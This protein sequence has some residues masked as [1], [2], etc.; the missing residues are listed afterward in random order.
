MNSISSNS[1]S[2]RDLEDVLEEEPQSKRG[3]QG[4]AAHGGDQAGANSAD[5]GK[6]QAPQTG[7]PRA[8]DRRPS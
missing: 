2:R 7:N 6:P 1:D 3:K 8:D 5:G 4:Q